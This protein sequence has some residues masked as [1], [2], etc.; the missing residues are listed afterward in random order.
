MNYFICVDVGTTSTKAVLYDE[1]TNVIKRFSQSYPLFRHPNGMAEQ[2]PT[3]IVNAVE[4][5]IGDAAQQ[6]NF[7]Q[8]KTT[9][10]CLF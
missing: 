3:T 2:D 8:R 10:R 4:K 5:V 1:H 7:F 9:C 6:I